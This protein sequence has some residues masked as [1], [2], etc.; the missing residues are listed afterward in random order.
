MCRPASSGVLSYIAST[1][2][3]FTLTASFEDLIRLIYSSRL[4]PSE[5]PVLMSD[6]YER[7]IIALQDELPSEISLLCRAIHDDDEHAVRELASSLHEGL[8]ITPKQCA[9]DS[10]KPQFLRLLLEEDHYMSESLM[11]RACEYKNREIVDV[12]LDYGCDIN[13]PFSPMGNAL[14]SVG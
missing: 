10:N 2:P 5:V 4:R 3:L 7:I 6:E 9:I 8:T 13:K 14:W 11:A 1:W 12:L